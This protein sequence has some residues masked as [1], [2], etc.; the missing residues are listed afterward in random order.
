[1]RI[2]SAADEIRFESNSWVQ[3]NAVN[4]GI[5]IGKVTE[6]YTENVRIESLDSLNCE[7]VTFKQTPQY[8]F[9]VNEECTVDSVEAFS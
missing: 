2:L 8:T 1:M 5:F 9:T 3:Y 7:T 4:E 6:S